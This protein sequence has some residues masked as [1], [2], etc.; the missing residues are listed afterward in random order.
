VINKS[1]LQSY[2]IFINYYFVRM[3]YQ[4]L[5]MNEFIW[6]DLSTYRL[7]E[8]VAFYSALFDWKFTNQDN[9]Y[10][11]GTDGYAHVGIYETPDFFKR[12]NMPH[13]WMNYIQTDNLENVVQ[14]AKAHG[15][16]VEIDNAPFYGGKIALIRDP[17]GAGFTVYE[18]TDLGK[19]KAASSSLIKSRELHTSISQNVISFYQELFDWHINLVSDTQYDIINNTGKR[20]G[21]ILELS[22]QF[23]GQ[24]EY[25][26]TEF[27][28]PN[29]SKTMTRLKDLGGEE[30]SNEGH[31]ILA[32][33]PFG[34]AFF[35]V[36][37]HE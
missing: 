9:Y 28:V 8:S 32:T 5:L 20:L 31:R 12:I 6:T 25:W 16:K 18:G 15:G 14:K 37:S 21:Q 2:S 30:I 4:E 11:G 19:N 7:T 33:D 29:L 26:A 35:Y 36:T 22:Y 34:E 13:F 27:F 24:Y 23:K 1:I 3:S 10:I 17:M